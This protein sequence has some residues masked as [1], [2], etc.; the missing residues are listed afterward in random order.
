[1]TFPTVR[2]AR[3]VH[4][5]A[6]PDGPL[7]DPGGRDNVERAW[8][9]QQ[10]VADLYTR[11]RNSFPAGIDPEELRDSAGVFGTTDAARSLQPALD[12]V[13]AEA[14][15]STQRLADA[16][17]SARV[18]DDQAIQAQRIWS[19]LQR[20]LDAAQGPAQK[21]SVA[22]DLIDSAEGLTLAT[23]QE[24][25]PD[26]LESS[27][28]PTGWLPAAFAARIPA[29]ADAVASGTKLAKAHAILQRNHQA[30]TRA[31]EKDTDVPP[32]LDPT[33]VDSTPYVNPSGF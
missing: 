11:Y 5:P 30:L 19:R 18:P 12:A 28:A 17:K 23:L 6:P 27:G 15:E 8:R 10:Q 1:M 31:I 16:V 25:L 29:A 13:K 20:K 4:V 32:L 2:P 14:D 33:R 24:E 26:Y 22:R 3:R 7:P 9:K 21:A